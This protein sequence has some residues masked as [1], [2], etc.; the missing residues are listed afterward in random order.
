MSAYQSM[1]NVESLQFFVPELLL[2]GFLAII[3]LADLVSRDG[4]PQPKL[5]AGLAVLGCAVATIGVIMSWSGEPRTLFMGMIVHDTLGHFLRVI[6]LLSTLVAVLLS[7]TS[8]EIRSRRSAEY[9]ALML[10]VGFGACLMVTASHVAMIYL[11]LEVVSIGSFILVALN[12]ENLKSSEAGLK[13]VLYGGVSSAV[14]LYGLSLLYGATGRLH[15]FQIREVLFSSLGLDVTLLFAL[16]LVLAGIGY[17]I[18]S[19][20]FHF[21]V[22]DVYEGAPT[23]I[24]AFLSVTSKVAGFGLLIRFLFHGLTETGVSLPSV[25]WPT[26]VAILSAVTMTLGNLGALAQK[27]LKRLLGY[28]SIAHAGYLLM[29]IVALN[30]EGLYAILFYAAVYLFMNL[31]AF[32]V[33]IALSEKLPSDDID[34]YRGLGWRCGFP[35][36]AMAIF[37]FALVGLPPTSGFT[38]K[39]FIFAAAIKANFIWLAIIGVLNAVISLYYYARIVKEMYLATPPEDAANAEPV[40]VS[41]SHTALLWVMVIPTIL[42]GIYFHPLLALA[43]SSVAVLFP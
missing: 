20:P 3:L 8:P 9:Y 2:V 25:D 17:K 29:G 31:G 34:S 19:V 36:V 14:M 40:T 35:C 33:I 13:Y 32:L 5:Y 6:V 27:N 22:P 15:L 18:A 7:A 16:L 38:G 41:A 43:K 4:R 24:T 12:K 10:A 39:F 21:W 37:M 26:L 42:L 28:S 30:A 23:P 11:A 1:M